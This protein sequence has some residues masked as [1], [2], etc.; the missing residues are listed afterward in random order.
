MNNAGTILLVRTLASFGLLIVSPAQA[1]NLSGTASSPAQSTMTQPIVKPDRVAPGVEGVA[2]T[3][4]VAPAATTTPAPT[5]R[6]KLKGK[7]IKSGDGGC[8]C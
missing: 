8:P 5:E 4:N 3:G 6:G 2:G 7:I 1:Q